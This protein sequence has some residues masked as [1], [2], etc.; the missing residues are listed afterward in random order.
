MRQPQG[1]TGQIDASDSAF[2]AL[3][4]EVSA[5]LEAGEA[6]DVDAVAIEHPAHA[7]RLGRLLPTLQ[8]MAQLRDSD[9]LGSAASRRSS[10]R[11][12]SEMRLLGDYRIGAQLGRGGMGVVYEAEQLSLAR[13]VALK[14]LPFAALLSEHQLRRFQTEAMAAARLQHPHIVPIYTV[15]CQR[16]IHYYAM[17]LIDG[18]SLADVIDQLRQ[19]RMSQVKSA[20]GDRPDTAE[21]VADVAANALTCDADAAEQYRA[22]ARVG[23]EAAE[24]LHYAH[25]HGVLHRDI[26]PS[27][28]LLDAAGHVRIVDFGLAR[29]DDESQVTRT[30]DVLGT[31]RYMSPEQAQGQRDKVDARSD[32]YSL[33][34]TLYEFATLQ[35]AFQATNRYQLVK[36]VTAGRPAAPH[37]LDPAMPRPLSLI[38][39]QAMARRPADRYQ[40]A[41]EL[42]DDLQRFLNGERVQAR[43]TSLLRQTSQWLRRHRLVCAVTVGLLAV[44]L[45]ATALTHHFFPGIPADSPAKGDDMKSSTAAKIASAVAA[46]SILASEA[47]PSAQAQTKKITY[48]CTDLGALSSI[49]PGSVARSISNPL[50]KNAVRVIGRSKADD[51]QYHAVIWERINNQWVF[52]DV[53]PEYY[54]SWGEGTNDL[55]QVVGYG[56]QQLGGADGGFFYD[57]LI[58]ME[59]LL[60]ADKYASQAYAINN[61]GQVVG[62]TRAT[63]E[64]SPPLNQAC[65][66]EPDGSGQWVTT[67]LSILA[68]H[69]RSFAVAINN[70]G[71]IVGYSNLDASNYYDHLPG[72]WE[73]VSGSWT[74]LNLNDAVGANG[75]DMMPRDINDMGQIVG[76]DYT[77]DAYFAVMWQRVNGQWTLTDLS[78][79]KPS[80]FTTTAAYGI[81]NLGQVVG[82]A[83]LTTGGLAPFLCEDGIM[84]DLSQFLPAWAA[85]WTNVSAK[86]INDHGQI[87]AGGYNTG[88]P[89]HALLIDTQQ[90]TYSYTS[91]G[92][93][94]SIKDKSTASKSMTLADNETITDLNVQVKLTHSR[95]ADLKFELV[96]PNNGTRLLCNAGAV[97]GSG[98][99]TLVFDDEGSA[100]SIVPAVPLSYYDGTSTQGKW[101]LKISDTVKNSK[102][103]SFTSFTLDVVPAL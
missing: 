61:S 62:N 98:T 82:T 55:G 28:V 75:S 43:P 32:V 34:A 58:G 54:Y 92:S 44:A 94:V 67:D 93:A 103:G 18:P 19:R 63:P 17:Q 73:N 90:V 83:S 102:T 49:T 64:D 101:T 50:D 35:P 42:A 36:Q 21:T 96:G 1:Q 71:Q 24:A 89:L 95:Y 4:Y 100:G 8:A 16:G 11:D 23:R 77:S 33:G 57:D 37:R 12:E 80:N 9:S 39:S 26:K 15:G 86:D 40:S 7:E 97:T 59:S 41:K 70:F 74:Y 51:G 6:V 30:G 29:V 10:E 31:L 13:R 81:N 72:F 69:Y 22:V 85:G 60:P 79:A 53:L 25:E 52:R 56:K 78:A 45:V 99:K 38:I 91:T 68:G 87:I 3:V 20:A 27:N 2:D 84:R 65:L 46:L 76:A 88:E 14:I 5:R 47:A 66:W 48:A